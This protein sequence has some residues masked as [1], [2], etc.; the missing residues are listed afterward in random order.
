MK[1][2]KR[3][4]LLI[5]ALFAFGG[6][7]AFARVV[8][9]VDEPFNPGAY[10]SLTDISWADSPSTFALRDLAG[11][12]GD[13]YD[14]TRHIKSILF[15]EKFESILGVEKNK[16][17]IDEL[18]T[19]PFD[20]SVFNETSRELDKHRET[21]A[22]M[23]LNVEKNVN[24]RQG[25]SDGW[26]D[27]DNNSYDRAAKQIWLDQTYM[28]VAEKAKLSLDEMDESFSAANAILAHTD[29]AEGQLQLLQAQN[30]LK[31]LLAYELARSNILDANMAQMQAAYH[32]SGYDEAV[33]SA[34]LLDQTTMSIADPYDEKND[35]LLRE[36]YEYTR[37]N[38]PGMPDF[39]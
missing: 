33:E 19:K 36:K 24:L 22:K 13:V 35:K 4:I 9:G 18:N 14:Y 17:A 37:P 11:A 32:E 16:T 34:Y 15:G 30:E 10:Y 29:E 39:E 2:F 21:T 27:Y 20:Q 28:S 8:P 25:L 3:G 38:A 31:T 12:G 5:P 7:V 26:E 6:A 23:T 1:K